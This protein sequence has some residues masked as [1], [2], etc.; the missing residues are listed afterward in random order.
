MQKK[1]YRNQNHS[2]EMWYSMEL[3][4]THLQLFLQASQNPAMLTMQISLKIHSL[5]ASQAACPALIQK[6]TYGVCGHPEAVLNIK[7]FREQLRLETLF[8]VEEPQVLSSQKTVR[9]HQHQ[10]KTRVLRPCYLL[11]SKGRSS[12]WRCSGFVT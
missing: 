1:V 7:H 4:S 3:D 8:L 11:G 2:L 9:R 6:R 10:N 5:C 12:P